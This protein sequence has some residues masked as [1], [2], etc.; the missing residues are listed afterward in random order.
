MNTKLR[1]SRFLI[2]TMIAG[3]GSIPAALRAGVVSV[4]G[5][6]AISEK[7]A[8][9]DA[10]R[11]AVERTGKIKIAS[12]STVQNYELAQDVIKTRVDGLVTHH[13]VK[14]KSKSPDGVW[15]VEVLADVQESVLDTTWADVLHLMEQ[16]GEPTITLF[17]DDLKQIA[18]APDPEPFERQSPVTTHIIKLLTDSGFRVIHRARYEFLKSKNMLDARDEDRYA[19]YKAEDTYGADIY[20]DGTAIAEGP[21]LLERSGL[22]KWRTTGRCTAYW[23]DSGEV[24]FATDLQD[25][26]KNFSDPSETNA[27]KLLD[28][29]AGEL[30]RQIKERL[31]E[32]LARRAVEGGVITIKFD[33]ADVDQQ[34]SIE[35]HLKE[36]ENVASVRLV[37][38]HDTAVILE[39]RTKLLMQTLERSLLRTKFDGFRLGVPQTEGRTV[40][41]R[42]KPAE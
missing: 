42:I 26:E 25:A 6:S 28:Y 16:L 21:M 27:I 35:D 40:V 7:E 23:S 34:F 32:T 39:V 17:F 30:G 41:F 20:L 38:R 18:G 4:T 33:D 29:T 9:N 3:V 12:W 5:Q 31:L 8:I 22:H 10:L 37:K 2:F 11:N 36:M 13:E 19:L 14:A 24:I 1:N 15:T